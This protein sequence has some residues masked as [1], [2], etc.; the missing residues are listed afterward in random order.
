MAMSRKNKMTPEEQRQMEE[1]K[2]WEL[3]DAAK[4][5]D[6]ARIQREID[7]AWEEHFA[8][9]DPATACSNVTTDQAKAVTADATASEN[10]EEE[11][12]AHM[13]A[14]A[15]KNTGAAKRKKERTIKKGRAAKVA[16]AEKQL[17]T[18]KR[19]AKKARPTSRKGIAHEEFCKAQR[20]VNNLRR[21]KQ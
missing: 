18:K 1:A 16:V 15:Q 11:I 21:N 2:A 10:L 14:I 7:Q 9:M 13:V 4:A 20:R 3:Y 8:E 12:D 5:E 17:D 19:E 6:K